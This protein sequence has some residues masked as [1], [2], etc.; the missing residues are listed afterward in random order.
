MTE[1]ASADANIVDEVHLSLAAL[2]E[3][4]R[5]SA[6][7]LSS[8]HSSTNEGGHDETTIDAAKKL[9]DSRPRVPLPSLRED[10][11]RALT[12]LL[13]EWM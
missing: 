8:L 4:R 10:E 11:K 5:L 13:A 9:F 1:L 6:H 3:L 2:I 12:L 7:A